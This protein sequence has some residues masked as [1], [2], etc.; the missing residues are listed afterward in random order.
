MPSTVRK[1]SKGAD[2]KLC[3][4]RLTLHGYPVAADGDFGSGTET[5]VIQFQQAK[6]LTGDGVVGDGTWN[7]LLAA[8]AGEVPPPE[9]LPEVLLQ[10]KRLGHKIPWKGDHHLFLFGIRSP[11]AQAGKFDDILGAAYTV[12]GMWR[13]HYWPGTTDPGTYYLTDKTKWYGSGGVAILAEG[14]YL[15]VWKIDVHGKY[16]ALCQRNGK[17]SVYHDNDLDNV[18]DYDPSTITSSSASGINLHAAVNDPYNVDSTKTDVGAWSAG[19]QVHARTDGFRD[20]MELAR[21]QVSERNISTF[22]YTL[23]KRWFA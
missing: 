4:E 18:L 17:V 11:N 1:G 12:K 10:A 2:V 6:G 21:K 15:D 19:C 22:S 13:V 20:M 8:P 5:K 23:F 3:Q 14:Q 16:E 7:I 9:P